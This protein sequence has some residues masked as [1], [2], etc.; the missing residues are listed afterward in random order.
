MQMA[1]RAALD[2]VQL[3]SVDSR[4]MISRVET[5]DGKENVTAVSLM[6]G[7][8]SR[9]TG[10]HRD[11]I[12]ITVK[13]FIRLKK[14]DMAARE[15]VLEKANA[16]A[17]NGGLLTTNNKSGR[18]IRVFRAQAAA[19]GDPWEWTKEYAIVLRACGVP[20]W[21][22]ST[23][24]TVTKTGV[25]SSTFSMTVGGSERTVTDVTFVN[26]SE[27]TC[28]TFQISTG[29][30]VIGFDSL[31]L[32]PGETLSIDHAD[33]GRGAYLRIRIKDTSNVWRSAM[34]KRT[35]GSSDDL[36]IMPG[37]QTVQMTSQRKGTLTASC[38]G[39]YA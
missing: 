31:G 39:R 21:Q 37:S 25:N 4:I 22:E 18:Q 9:V 26:T 23:P 28:N 30:G 29:T 36:Y 19:A 17:A 20:Y 33:T 27:A 24:V 13:F 32:A 11:S 12:D 7:S 35:P 6:G 14:R 15:T 3:D 1:H 5:G 38:S 2:G 10:I 8:G 34:A 16:W